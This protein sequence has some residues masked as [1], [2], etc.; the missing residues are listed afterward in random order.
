MG[1]E[2]SFGDF[3]F[4]VIAGLTATL[5]AWLLSH[6]MRRIRYRRNKLIAHY[7][8]T[9]LL[10]I[11]GAIPIY[12]AASWFL[13]LTLSKG[14]LGLAFCAWLLQLVAVYYLWRLTRRVVRDEQFRDRTYRVRTLED[15]V[16]PM[17][18][19]VRRLY[20]ESPDPNDRL[21]LSSATLFAGIGFLIRQIRRYA[22]KIEPDLCVGVNEPG[23]AMA[24]LFA[25]KIH[26]GGICVGYICTRGTSDHRVTQHVL[27]E[28][29][30][31]AVPG[32]RPLILLADSE[33]KGGRSIQH[34]SKYLLDR[35]GTNV[36]IYVAVLV[37]SQVKSDRI[38]HVKE[39]RRGDKGVFEV[40]DRYLPNFLAFT[41]FNKVGLSDDI[42]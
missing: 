35:Y 39:L 14:Q 10:I 41:C 3:L 36:D 37:A 5:I 8:L 22:P 1:S 17:T 26:H 9:L 21:E 28:D 18:I 29:L 27:P 15:R 2:L 19:P 7:A 32:R 6:A 42:R 25:E 38:D 31:P 16:P 20:K 12:Y 30:K 24:S 13:E 33:I 23:T 11:T 40:N 34:A 4:A